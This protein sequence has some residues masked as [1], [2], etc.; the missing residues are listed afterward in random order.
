ME[1]RVAGAADV[2]WIAQLHTDSWR[3]TY[4]GMYRDDFLDGDLPGNRRAVWRE[5]L[6]HPPSNQYV[7]VAVAEGQMAGFVC[8]Y[9][10]DDATWGSLIDNLH[11]AAEF[12][13]R[14]IGK[15]LM[16]QAADW[17]ISAYSDCGVYLWVLE[18]NT[19]ARRFYESLGATH[20]ETVEKELHPGGRGRICRYAWSNPASL[21]GAE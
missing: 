8:V 16:N 1:Y 6:T 3:S 7:V 5:R 13:R 9:G 20:V 15:A 2:E 18:G 21:A 10:A 19:A 11:V 14:G 4:R 12:Q 17:L